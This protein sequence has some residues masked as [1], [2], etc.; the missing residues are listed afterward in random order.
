MARGARG[1]RDHRL[2][3]AAV[4]QSAAIS[5][6]LEKMGARLPPGSW[7]A[8]A[9]PINP[10]TVDLKSFDCCWFL[11][12]WD[13]IEVLSEEEEEEEKGRRRRWRRL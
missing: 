3:G 12:T 13:P 11:P 2:F 8:Y 7:L 4:S 5:L 6:A 9:P 1:V 10:M